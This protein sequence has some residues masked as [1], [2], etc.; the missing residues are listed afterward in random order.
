MEA[1][2]RRAVPKGRRSYN[3]KTIVKKCIKSC[4]KKIIKKRIKSCKKNYK[5]CKKCIQNCK[6]NCSPIEVLQLNSLIAR[7]IRTNGN[8][9]ETYKSLQKKFQKTVTI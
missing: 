4:K 2:A 5:N 1:V 7:K 8:T 3:Y 9:V 6:K